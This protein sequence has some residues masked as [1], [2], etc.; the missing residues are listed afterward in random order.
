M[1]SNIR[2]CFH[3]TLH[4]SFIWVCMLWS[5]MAVMTKTYQRPN[6]VL[7]LTDDLDISIGG[8]VSFWLL[9]FTDVN[10]KSFWSFRQPVFPFYVYRFH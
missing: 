3:T 4:L 5:S 9:S 1:A 6:I 7:I 8:M 10:M 2:L